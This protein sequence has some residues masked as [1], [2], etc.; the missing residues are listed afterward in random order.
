M[1]LE[2]KK[3]SL[4]DFLGRGGVHGLGLS[5]AQQ[6]IKVY[7]DQRPHTDEAATLAELQRLAAPYG[8]VV[9]R[10]ETAHLQKPTAAESKPPASPGF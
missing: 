1:T 5:R 3:R 10:E 6:A 9:I 8:I 4:G 7:L 2:E